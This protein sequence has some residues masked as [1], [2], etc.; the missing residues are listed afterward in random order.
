MI[1]VFRIF[2]QAQFWDKIISSG[3]LESAMIGRY[4]LFIFCEPI[5]T[6]NSRHFILAKVA[7]RNY[8]FSIERTL[9]F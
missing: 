4:M 6:E 3:L 1:I 7:I 2:F 8:S 5:R 9:S